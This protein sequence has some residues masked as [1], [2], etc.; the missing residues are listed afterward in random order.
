MPSP[1]A[2][3]PRAGRWLVQRVMLM[4]SPLLAVAAAASAIKGWGLVALA[5]ILLAFAFFVLGR[6]A[7][8]HREPPGSG[9]GDG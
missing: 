2:S 6:P 4:T 3:T 1:E 8:G 9:G 7:Q 5:L